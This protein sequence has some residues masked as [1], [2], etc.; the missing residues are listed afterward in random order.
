MRWISDE[1]DTCSYKNVNRQSKIHF[2]HSKKQNINFK[3]PLTTLLKINEILKIIQIHNK[4]IHFQK[5]E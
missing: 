4:R 3:T 2:I 1:S 5:Y